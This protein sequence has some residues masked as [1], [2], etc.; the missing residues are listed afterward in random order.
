M[1]INYSLTTELEAINVM[2]AIIGE[3]P[4]NSIDVVGM[5]DVATAKATLHEASKEIQMQGWYCN[6]EK[7]YPFPKD[8]N[9][10][11]NIPNNVLRYELSRCVDNGRIEV[12][13]KDGKLY[14]KKNHTFV[15]ENDLKF[16]VIWFL[17]YSDLPE[18]LRR[19]INISAARKFQKRFYSSD[20][21][22]A[23]TREDELK[24]MTQA[25][26]ADGNEGNYNMTQNESVYN[27]IMR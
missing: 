27:I 11:I 15:F 16:D 24:A 13:K 2:L 12:V 25:K 20:T 26:H 6:T 4:V 23:F 10:N 21:I 1:A 3:A 18:A 9:G 17:P 5:V 22:D 7:E 19:Y 14:D 8:I